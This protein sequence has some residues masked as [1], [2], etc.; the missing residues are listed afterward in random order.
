VYASKYSAWHS[1]AA[2]CHN[3]IFLYVSSIGNSSSTILYPFSI[4]FCLAE[5]KAS[6]TSGSIFSKPKFEGIIN[7]KL[8]LLAF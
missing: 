5:L 8:L 7:F 4:I 2:N 6:S 1:T 3:G